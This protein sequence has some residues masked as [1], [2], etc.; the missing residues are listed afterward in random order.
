MVP[1]GGLDGGGGGNGCGD[2]G[3]VD[4]SVGAEGA[5]GT[6]HIAQA[7]QRQKPQSS[8]ACFGW[9]RLASHSSVDE[10]YDIIGVQFVGSG[11]IAE[12]AARRGCVAGFAVGCIVTGGGGE[13]EK[14]G[15]TKF[16]HAEHARQLQSVHCDSLV[17]VTWHLRMS[18]MQMYTSLPD[19]RSGAG[20]FC[21]PLHASLVAIIGATSWRTFW[22]VHGAA[23]CALS[24]SIEVT[25][26]GPAHA[27]ATELWAVEGCRNAEEQRVHGHP[28]FVDE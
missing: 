17:G 26:V 9:H 28:H 27:A 8:T 14:G 20:E 2:G 23:R 7:L 21:T 12:C 22:S 24:T 16:A 5:V 4:G 15:A 1:R 25:V 19:L 3:G 11:R 18:F 10:S 6:L 13:G